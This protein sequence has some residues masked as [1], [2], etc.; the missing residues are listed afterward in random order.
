MGPAAACFRERDR[1]G[2]SFNLFRLSPPLAA[3]TRGVSRGPASTEPTQPAREVGGRRGGAPGSGRLDGAWKARG[4]WGDP[5]PA[6]PLIA[7]RDA[8]A[9][10][11]TPSML[12]LTDGRRRRT[13]TR[14]GLE[15][16]RTGAAALGS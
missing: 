9:P 2:P 7:W 3:R 13:G 15:R 14:T 8:V 5:A 10:G 16:A 6:L 11:S 1:P 12:A 4:G